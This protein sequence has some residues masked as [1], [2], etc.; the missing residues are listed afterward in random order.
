MASFP[1][2][3][4]CQPQLLGLGGRK[5]SLGAFIQRMSDMRKR[6]EKHSRQIEQA[7]AT[8]TPV[9]SFSLTI[10]R[11]RKRRW[12]RLMLKSVS[13]PTLNNRAGAPTAEERRLLFSCVLILLFHA[14]FYYR[15]LGRG[16]RRRGRQRSRP[17]PQPR[18]PSIYQSVCRLIYQR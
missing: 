7:A 6:G 10:H 2:L 4:A 17:R 13:L 1:T 12:I 14:E 15:H 11:P 5:S 18:R 8:Q 3:T 16:G 9:L